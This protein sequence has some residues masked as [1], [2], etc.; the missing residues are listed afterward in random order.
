MAVMVVA[1]RAV[2]RAVAKAVVVA[3]EVTLMMGAVAMAAL[4]WW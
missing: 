2:A 3:V 4:M 1:V